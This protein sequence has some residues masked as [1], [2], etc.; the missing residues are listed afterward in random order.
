M[1]MVKV[2]I[3]QNS[4]C[5]LAEKSTTRSRACIRGLLKDFRKTSEKNSTSTVK[6]SIEVLI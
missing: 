5:Q 6:S 4:S 1:V 3:T 2:K